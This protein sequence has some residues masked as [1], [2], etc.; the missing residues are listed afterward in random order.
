[1]TDKVPYG[2]RSHFRPGVLLKVQLGGN[3]PT[4]NG[5][6]PLGQER[7]EFEVICHLKEGELVIGMGI[8]H[9][10]KVPYVRVLTRDGVCGIL[11]PTLVKVV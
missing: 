2:E 5:V 8:S 6:V 4:W 10:R 9:A 3:F 11:Y 7:E 1:M